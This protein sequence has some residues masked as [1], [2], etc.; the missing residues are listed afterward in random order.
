MNSNNAIILF[1]GVCNLCNSS[2]QFILKRDKNAYFQFASLQS[3]FGQTLL[4]KYNL[5]VDK[6]ESIVLVENEKAFLYS[7][8]ALKIAKKL[9]GFWPLFYLFIVVPPVIRNFFYRLVAQNRYK[10]FGKKE[11]CLI[12]KPEW[13]ERFIND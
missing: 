1:D 11:E 12:P 8:A 5:Q 7:T 13:K 9:S 4:A 3:E 2:V 6:F 10:I